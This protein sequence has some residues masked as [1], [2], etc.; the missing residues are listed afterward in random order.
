MNDEKLVFR[1]YFREI[2]LHFREIYISFEIFYF[3]TYFEDI[4]ENKHKLWIKCSKT[5]N[6]IFPYSCILK[7]KF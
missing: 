5:Y 1:N 2:F 4:V 7:N 6:D 3:C